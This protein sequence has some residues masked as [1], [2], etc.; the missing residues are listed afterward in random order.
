MA[1]DPR[2]IAFDDQEVVEL[3]NMYSLLNREC[4]IAN[5]EKRQKI[6]DISARQGRR[7]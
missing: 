7:I 4:H 5:Q 1:N 6:M 3:R 2:K